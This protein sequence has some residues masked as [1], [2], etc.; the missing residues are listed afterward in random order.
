MKR[1]VLIDGSAIL[2]RAYHA[3]P[4]LTAPDGSPVGAVYGFTS[5]LFK[6]VND[7]QPTHLAVAFDRPA[8]TFR[9]ELY[10]DYQ[11]QRPKMEDELGAQVGKVHETIAAFGI[12]IYEVDGFEADDVLASI[13]HR[14]QDERKIFRTHQSPQVIIVTGDRDL[15]QLVEDDR[16]LVYMP[17][18]GLS[19]AK[20]Y[21]E[22]E[23]KEKLGVAPEQISDF[24]ALAGDASD[25]YPGVP[26]IGPKTAAKLLEQFGSVEKLY[27]AAEEKGY[28]PAALREKLKAGRESAKLGRELATVRIDVP[29]EVSLMEMELR[30]LETPES[31]KMLERLN[32]QSLL[33]RLRGDK[34][35]EA[36]DKSKRKKKNQKGKTENGSEQQSLF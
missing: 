16:V 12:P 24:K 27:Q 1:L 26:G 23:V 36:S 6:I 13:T 17:V 11:A 4:P 29:I 28:L 14:V 19:E 18:K 9:Q 32:F 35:E 21:G 33:K 7:L 15:L 10:K 5:M 34:R 22:K 31:R 20:L 25:N 3:L 30:T 8:P 2:H